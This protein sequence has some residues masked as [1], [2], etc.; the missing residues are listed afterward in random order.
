MMPVMVTTIPKKPSSQADI[1][2]AVP[3]PALM[4]MFQ[5]IKATN[6]TLGPGADCAKAMEEEKEAKEKAKHGNN[7]G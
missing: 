4:P 6:R 1:P 3:P 7:T 5:P 2:D